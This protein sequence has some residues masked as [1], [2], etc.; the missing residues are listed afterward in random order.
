MNE[1]QLHRKRE[2]KEYSLGHRAM[3]ESA[4]ALLQD[5][6][7]KILEVGFGIGWGLDKMLKANCVDEYL[8]V[9][10]CKESFDFV[11]QYLETNPNPK[12]TLEH[13]CWTDLM[14]SRIEKDF[15]ADFS[16]CIEV[17]EHIPGHEHYAFLK[18]LAKFTDKALFLSTPNKKTSSH[19]LVAPDQCADFL[20]LAGFKSV[21]WIEW[22][23][24]TFFTAMK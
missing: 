18:K 22:Q 10:P 17:L 14:E 23:W 6:P 4:I 3:Y 5:K 12:V 2:G 1:V 13:A 15:I 21:T 8:G 19:G 11:T 9:E 7:A 24:T 20:K 16:F